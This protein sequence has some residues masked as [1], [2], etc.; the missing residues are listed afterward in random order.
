MILNTTS[1]HYDLS[2]GHKVYIYHPAYEESQSYLFH[3]HASDHPEGGF[4]HALALNGCALIA[5]NRLDDF[6]SRSRGDAQLH[7]ALNEI[8]SSENYF[9]HMS[10]KL[11]KA[12]EITRKNAKL[13]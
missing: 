6:L 10:D 1:L 12:D 7:M 13:R 4:L 11:K 8:L 9:F 2:S 3:L 5:K